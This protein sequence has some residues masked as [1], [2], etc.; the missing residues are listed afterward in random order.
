[1]DQP[2]PIELLKQRSLQEWA[3]TLP[4]FILLIAIVFFSSAGMMHARMME[5]GNLWW[6][7]YVEL[8]S[9][10]VQP[11]CNININVDA[12]VA[13]LAANANQQVPDELDLLFDEAPAAVDHSALKQSVEQ[14]L[15]ECQNSHQK[16]QSLSNGLTP[17]L[18]VW[19]WVEHQFEAITKVGVEQQRLLLAAL[20]LLCGLTTALARKHISLRPCHSKIDYR[21]SAFSQMVASIIMLISI[22]SFR[23]QTLASG[24]AVPTIHEILLLC[25]SGG[26]SVLTLVSLWQCISVPKETS[27]D[28][29]F[30]K[31]LA[32]IPLYAF[33][34]G[35]SG[36]YFFYTGHFSG[37]GIYLNQMMELSQLFLN[38]GLYVWIG[39]MLKQTRLAELVFDVLRPWQ[40]PAELLGVITLLI[41]AWPTAWT[42]AS[43]IFVIAVAAMVYQEL[44]R[45]GARRQL[46]LATTAMAGSMGVVLRPCLLVVII[47]A[48]NKQVTT[49]ELF[50]WGIWVFLLSI[51]LFLL[52]V[53]LTSKIN[54]QLTHWKNALPQS[55][56][57]AKKLIPYILICAVVLVLY[58]L[59]LGAALDEFNAPVILPVIMLSLLLYDR[60]LRKREP[61]ESDDQAPFAFLLR[62]R[63]AT[64]E[65]TVHIGALLLMMGMTISIGGVFDRAEIMSLAPA[66][67]AN[68]WL[69]MS[70]LVCL[71]VLLGMVMDPYGAVILVTASITSLAYQSGINPVHFWMV[72]LVAFELGYLSPPVALNHLL[73]RQVIGG[74]EVWLAAHEHHKS[75]WR[76]H[77]RYLLPMTTMG[78]TLLLVAYVPLFFY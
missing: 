27:G 53:L 5:L 26:F 29:S 14:S 44:R 15:A 13:E 25:W 71:L 75:F 64:N 74:R 19:R 59:V 39:M 62:I 77:E 11:T 24:I 23:N 37:L 52:I 70:L 58:Q 61:H 38:V 1:M 21:V 12:R 67:L 35:I 72:A 8:R 51:G 46:A 49:R 17:S 78:I 48:L 34:C 36:G 33:M 56:A 20:V 43:G 10:L 30:S 66:Q 6:S 65:T 47:A 18:I 54:W 7:D 28:E 69:A 76:R 31:A 40:L 4:A 3:S 55:L 50:D 63:L 42:G 45:A 2:A 32:C 57:A 9:D 68:P 41:A 73:T 60:R 22:T 16:W